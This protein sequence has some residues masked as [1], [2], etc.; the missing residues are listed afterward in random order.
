MKRKEFL[1]FDDYFMSVALLSAQR[2]KDPNRQVGACIVNASQRIVG[3]GYNGF[4]TGCSDDVLPW[5]GREDPTRKESAPMTVTHSMLETKYP[6][7]CHAELNAIMNSNMELRG[8]VIYCTLFP[9]NECA[10][11]IIQSGICEVI[12]LS[13]KNHNEPS[14]VASRRLLELGGIKYAAHSPETHSISLSLQ[15]S[16]EPAC[17][18]RAVHH[19]RRFSR[20]E[21]V[22]LSMVAIVCCRYAIDYF[23]K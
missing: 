23:R 18:K 2:S 8:C 19:R 4:P 22:L 12:Y 7:V 16:A 15:E 1:S 9:C 21:F 14:W 20:E 17:I 13:D 3:I 10:K 6:Y 5:K 11:L